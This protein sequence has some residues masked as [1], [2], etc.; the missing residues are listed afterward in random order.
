MGLRVAVVG[1]CAA[2]KSSVVAGLRE[3]GLEAYSVAQEHS[4]V[5]DLWKHL[6]PDRVVYLDVSLDGVRARR[7]D[8]S[9]PVWIYEAQQE[10]LRDARAHAN[11]VVVTDGRDVGEVV[12]T[13]MAVLSP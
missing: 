2:G 12:E 11:V 3:R 9:W 6:G 4:A 1:S 7:D 13:V 8:P 5:H 10:R